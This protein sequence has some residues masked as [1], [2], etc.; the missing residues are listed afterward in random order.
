M[1]KKNNEQT[2]SAS[3]VVFVFLVFIAAVILTVMY[4]ANYRTGNKRFFGSTN[5]VVSNELDDLIKKQ[6]KQ[7]NI[8]NESLKK[9]YTF[10]NPYVLENPFKINPLSALIIFNTD[11]SKSISISINGNTVYNTEN[12][13]AHIIPI[14]GLYSN[15]KN[16]VKLQ[17]D[18][19]VKE[20]EIQTSPYNN[21]LGD[22]KV[23]D[24]LDKKSHLFMVG[25]LN[26]GKSALR[27]LDENNNLVLYLNMGKFS[28]FNIVDDRIYVEYKVDDDM[29]GL[30]L[31][32]DYLGKIYS[33]TSSYKYD[34]KEPN[35]NIEASSYIFKPFNLYKPEVANYKTQELFS[36]DSNSYKNVIFFDDIE[37][38]LDNAESY[39][40]NFSIYSANDFIFFSF[41][42][43]ASELIIVAEDTNYVYEYS[44]DNINMIKHDIEGK[45]ALFVKINDNIYKLNNIVE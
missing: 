37:N 5:A 11:E 31:E 27:A 10:D 34:I 7:D 39:N 36:S 38:E 45:K 16:I 32:M 4:S 17:M 33:I 2:I 22:I 6:S 12:S 13:K 28:N 19:K 9:G 20:I 42:D 3:V 24:Y 41:A 21:Y 29:P 18:D 26:D 30:T 43:K 23:S 25:D 35:L 8:I 44:I 15:S 40:N 1:K 14:Y